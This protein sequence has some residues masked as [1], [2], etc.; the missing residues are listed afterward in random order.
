M[1]LDRWA[2]VLGVFA[3]ILGVCLSLD[4]R[5]KCREVMKEAKVTRVEAEQL[6]ERTLWYLVEIKARL[7]ELEKRN[8]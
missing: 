5:E 7:E 1:T 6:N 3:G 2:A 4:S 8:K